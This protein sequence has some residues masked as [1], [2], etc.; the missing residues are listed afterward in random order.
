M[1]SNSP[2]ESWDNT[3]S[4]CELIAYFQSKGGTME[5]LGKS[6]I[7]GHDD[8]DDDDDDYFKKRIPWGIFKCIYKCVENLWKIKPRVSHVSSD[9]LNKTQISK[10][11]K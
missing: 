8:D 1:K 6:W 10:E 2:F 5:W 7:D 3:C 11:L 9:N 4:L